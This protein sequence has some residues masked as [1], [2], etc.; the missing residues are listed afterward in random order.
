MEKKSGTV[1]VTTFIIGL[2]AVAAIVGAGVYFLASQPA[3]AEPTA[4]EEAAPVDMAVTPKY[5]LNVE[6]AY[7]L[8]ME[9]HAFE[10]W[11]HT[12]VSMSTGSKLPLPLAT[13]PVGVAIRGRR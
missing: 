6:T 1:S 4:S 12:R 10:D 11:G 2:V 9:R 3:P 13:S 5:D 8:T 7:K